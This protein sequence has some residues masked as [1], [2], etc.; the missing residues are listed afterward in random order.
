[1]AEDPFQSFNATVAGIRAQQNAQAA[2]QAA[3]AQKLKDDEELRTKLGELPVGANTMDLDE[4]RKAWGGLVAQKGEFFTKA[5]GE[6]YTIREGGAPKGY[7]LRDLETY[8]DPKTGKSI[9]KSTFYTVPQGA[10]APAGLP[11]HLTDPLRPVADEDI[12]QLMQ[13]PMVASTVNALRYPKYGNKAFSE[14]TGS[15]RNDAVHQALTVLRDQVYSSAFPSHTIATTGWQYANGA[16][17]PEKPKTQPFWSS[18]GN[19]WTNASQH[20][21]NSLIPRSLG[22]AY[23]GM[24]AKRDLQ[25]TMR[26]FQ[27]LGSPGHDTMV[28]ATDRIMESL[29]EKR[30]RDRGEKIGSVDEAGN[31]TGSVGGAGYANDVNVTPIQWNAEK[32][33][34]DAIMRMRSNG[35]KIKMSDGSEKTWDAMSDSEKRS[36]AFGAFQGEFQRS[37]GVRQRE[38]EAYSR[39]DAAQRANAHPTT[40]GADMFG[41]S[42]A[43]RT[44]DYLGDKSKE[45]LAG[46]THFLPTLVEMTALSEATAGKL[47]GQGLG[48]AGNYLPHMAGFVPFAK[49]EYDAGQQQAAEEMLQQG[50][51]PRDISHVLDRMRDRNLAGKG[52]S[53]DEVA[54]A[55]ERRGAIRAASM[56]A[57]A[58]IAS[59]TVSNLTGRALGYVGTDLAKLFKIPAPVPVVKDAIAKGVAADAHGM[60]PEGMTAAQKSAIVLGRLFTTGA[61]NVAGMTAMNIPSDVLTGQPI[62]PGMKSGAEMGAAFLPF[63]LL[64]SNITQWN[65]YNG[66]PSVNN[67]PN[68]RVSPFEFNRSVYLATDPAI[69]FTRPFQPLT[70]DPVTKAGPNMV[71]IPLEGY[72]TQ[73]PY[74][75]TLY[76]SDYLSWLRSISTTPPPAPQMG[77]GGASK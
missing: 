71:S 34:R 63:N 29:G 31:S 64:H 67:E 32:N 36:V 5:P 39:Y 33:T 13:I 28:N 15:E 50:A 17:E 51:S 9:V 3:A 1:M 62:G 2:A 19:E 77:A 65:H 41:D 43:G 55:A 54:N 27:Y 21:V 58:P 69:T 57:L 76:P 66:I 48:W 25:D 20:L 6:N 30:L 4:A 11:P 14:L 61:K 53:F 46:L 73:Q 40:A 74:G 35:Q 26:T 75:T 8:T 59:S 72:T 42:W 37:F 60:F 7:H 12:A 10:Q 16:P 38:G 68:G 23:P 56:T 49:D 44:T 47:A 52:Q 45:G 18:I 70:Y 24:D 22:E